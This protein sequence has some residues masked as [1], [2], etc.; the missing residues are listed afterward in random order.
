MKLKI[1]YLSALLLLLLLQS[2]CDRACEHEIKVDNDYHAREIIVEP[3]KVTISSDGGIEYFSVTNCDDWAFF[4]ILSDETLYVGDMISG[5]LISFEYFE[6]KKINNKTFSV[7]FAK[8]S[9]GK[10]RLLDIE[11]KRPNNELG[12]GVVY[13]THSK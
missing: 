10:D 6:I 5:E 2:S 8:N 7:E 11:L 12:V 13:I 9:S 1:K 3:K 4:K